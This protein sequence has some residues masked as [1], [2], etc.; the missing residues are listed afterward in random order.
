MS[1]RF[2]P[3]A[4]F[5]LAM[6]ILVAIILFSVTVQY[7]VPDHRPPVIKIL[8]PL[9]PFKRDGGGGQRQPL[10]AH[11]GQAPKAVA[12]KVWVPPMVTQIETPK[13]VVVAALS[14]APDYNI[15]AP[16]VGDP[17]GHLGIPS[18]GSGLNGI[19]GPGKDGV[20]V[21]N[22]PHQG[23]NPMPIPIYRGKLTRDPQLIYKEEPEFSDEARKARHEGTVIIDL[24]IDANG[25]PVNIHVVRG[26]GMGLDERALAAVAHWKFRPAMAGD[27]AVAAP[28]RVS[29][30]FHLL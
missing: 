23:G 5:S 2:K 30:T 16:N 18:A 28:A 25:R 10:P 6:H 17:L 14:E 9:S 13:L 29:V 27:R 4:A 1:R 8:A 24:D 12:R 21:G 26:L 7:T 11:R 15:S 22:G 19:G 3:A 20:G